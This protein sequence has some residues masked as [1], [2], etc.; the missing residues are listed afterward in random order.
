MTTDLTRRRLLGRALSVSGGLAAAGLFRTGGYAQD[1][2]PEVGPPAGGSAEDLALTPE[3][4]EEIRG[5]GLRFGFHTNHRTDDFI[6]T[7]IAGGE[8]TA[9]EYGIEL[10][11]GE[12][13]FNAG[14]QLADI[15]ALIQQQVDG[16]FLVA[17]DFTAISPAI[18]RAN[19]ADIPVVIVG[20]PPARGE[21]VTVL[22]STSY[23]GCYDS[24]AFLMETVGDGAQVGVITIPLAL[25]T[26]QER[27]RGAEAAIRDGGGEIVATQ[28]VGSQD[29]ALNAAQNMLQ[30]NS[31]LA[32][33]FATWSL[34]VNGALAA[35]EASGRDVALCGY[36]A[37][38]AGFQAFEA[39]N[40]HLYALSGQQPILQ[41]RVGLDA[42]CRAKLGLEVPPEIETPTLLVTREN[43]EEMWDRLYPGVPMPWE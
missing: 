32:G 31:E 25:E 3:Q 10:L 36:D 13:G 40:P 4:I 17:V 30:A 14:K 2:T 19:Q 15:E 22:N 43:Y 27:D 26:I 37:E 18:V 5:M 12:A 41:G 21:V 33:I 11:V 34:A 6:N 23:Q 42:L 16:I 7:L 1:A 28:A 39:G 38:V 8:Q 9:E 24:A 20:G 35:I 29:E